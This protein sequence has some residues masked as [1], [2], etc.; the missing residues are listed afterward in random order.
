MI[1]TLPGGEE[2]AFADSAGRG[3][4]QDTSEGICRLKETFDAISTQA[5]P[6]KLSADLI[7]RTIEE[8]W[9]V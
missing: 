4:M 6:T 8:K 9:T 5:L 7:N 1:A 2:V 3:I